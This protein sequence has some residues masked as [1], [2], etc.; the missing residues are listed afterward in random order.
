MCGI[1]GF[2]NLQPRP[3]TGRAELT[4][5]VR[6]MSD[7]L[8]HRGPDD[9]GTWVDPKTGVALG[10]RRLA[11]VDLSPAGHQ[12]MESASGR[13]VMV[14][15]GEIYNHRELRRQLLH[16]GGSPA[17]FRG[18][19]DTEV[20]LAGIEAWGLRPALERTV[21]MF[22]IA[23]W[24]RHDET[25]S[26]A[27]DRVGEK[28]LYY[29]RHGQTLL[30]GSEPQPLLAHEAFDGQIDRDG[31]GSVSRAWLHPGLP[32]RFIDRSRS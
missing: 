5:Q 14:F 2:L 19:S 25:L 32:I 7:R 17:V 18:H 16:E 1:T 12:P 15:N 20:L 4:A 9:A 29:G 13:Y 22:A 3:A 27:R 28:P 8:I 11:I 23:V 30:F 6:T 24:D 31:S 21:G 10:F 26:L